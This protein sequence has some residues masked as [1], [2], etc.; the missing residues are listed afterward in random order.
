MISSSLGLYYEEQTEIDPQLK[1]A[2]TSPL[3]SFAKSNSEGQI[4]RKIYKHGHPVRVVYNESEGIYGHLNLP[5]KLG[6]GCSWSPVQYLVD[7]AAKCSKILT[8]DKCSKNT[9]VSC[10]ILAV[11]DNYLIVDLNFFYLNQN[12]NS[13]QRFRE[14]MKS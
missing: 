10:N 6:S 8:P 14:I 5:A 12:R 1:P 13:Q 7:S 4:W 2:T 11:H 9:L 3:G